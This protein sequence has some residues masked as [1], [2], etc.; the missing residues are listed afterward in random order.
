MRIKRDKGEVTI[1]LL[2]FESS[3]IL[4]NE[5]GITTVT[6]FQGNWQQVMGHIQERFIE[7]VHANPWLAGRLVK[8]KRSNKLQLVHPQV[9]PPEM[10]AR[11]FIAN[12]SQFKINSKM[13]Y[14]S[15]CDTLRTVIVLRASDMDS[16]SPLC[17]LTLIPDAEYPQQKF[18]IIFSLAHVIADGA[19]YYQ[20]FN[21]IFR[22]GPILALR[23]KRNQQAAN[24]MM[25]TIGAKEYKYIFSLSFVLNNLRE[26]WFAKKK[27]YI[28]YVDQEKIN[29][30]KKNISENSGGNVN[31]VSNN[32]ILSSS[33]ARLIGA[34]TF[35][36][37]MNLRR[38]IKGINN[39]DA[40]NYVAPLCFD[41]VICK[42]PVLIRKMLDQG[43]PFKTRTKPF[44]GFWK[45][46]FSKMALITN[47][48]TFAGDFTLE[49]CKQLLHIPVYENKNVPY[50]TAA[51]FQAQPGRLAVA[52]WV[53]SIE[54]SH[55]LAT[56]ELGEAL[57]D[58]N[59]G[60]R[61]NE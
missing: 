60:I 59:E 49:G 50:D 55:L 32:D 37:V 1:P 7:I 48:S 29:V 23:T 39:E 54:K 8:I 17:L 9:P 34:E 41:D 38:R 40:G 14:P 42:D 30:A 13:S 51:I 35:M 11:L 26:M 58:K 10:T 52:F 46:I 3:W 21:Q 18:A 15:L 25:W 4:K 16:V 6:F 47:W 31:F 53:S 44:P 12:P 5:P 45:T 36:I 22:K 61:M 20:I 19:T 56:R 33:F 2:D 27:F 24:N 57:L 28:F 43:P